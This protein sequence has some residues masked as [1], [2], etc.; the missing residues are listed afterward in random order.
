VTVSLHETKGQNVA[1]PQL[2]Y[3]RSV[4]LAPTGVTFSNCFTPAPF[5]LP[6]YSAVT[7]YSPVEPITYTMPS[8]ITAHTS[9]RLLFS[10]PHVFTSTNWNDDSSRLHPVFWVFSLIKNVGRRGNTPHVASCCS[11]GDNG[12]RGETTERAARGRGNTALKSN[13]LGVII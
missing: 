1:N 11:R 9:F 8:S 2:C 12:Q 13:E 7:K 6:P 4:P 3:Q 5:T 10:G